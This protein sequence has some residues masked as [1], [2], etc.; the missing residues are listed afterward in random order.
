MVLGRRAGILALLAAD[1]DA[2]VQAWHWS[3]FWPPP[4]HRQTIAFGLRAGL[5]DDSGAASALSG[6]LAMKCL[7]SEHTAAGCAIDQ[8]VHFALTRALRGSIGCTWRSF[9]PPLHD[10]LTTSPLVHDA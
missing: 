3:G 8:K 5:A 9:T 1:I 2:L 4:V 10:P 7:K 6:A